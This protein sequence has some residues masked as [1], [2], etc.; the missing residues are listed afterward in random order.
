MS[1]AA[2]LSSA[3]MSPADMIAQALPGPGATKEHTKEAA[4]KFEGMLMA[5]LFQDMRKTV[6]AS[7]LFGNEGT[8][9]STY[10]YLLDQAV[11]T[12]AM[13]AGKGWGLSQ[14]LEAAWDARSAKAKP[15]GDQDLI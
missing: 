6:Q 2:L 12:N 4:E 7:G 3:Q 13:A 14:R 8:A 1:D 5:Y 15:A 11:S 10:E 9:R